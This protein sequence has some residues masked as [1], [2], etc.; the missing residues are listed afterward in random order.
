MKLEALSDTTTSGRLKVAN[1]FL[2]KVMVAAVIVVGCTSS[3]LECVSIINRNIRPIN[4]P[5]SRCVLESKALWAMTTDVVGLQG[6]IS[7][8][9]GRDH[10][11]SH[12]VLHLYPR[13]PHIA[14]NK[15]LHA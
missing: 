5:C 15:A 3:H 10:I 4:G 13:P 8:F 11:I 7:D 1:D 6:E 12:I 9:A 2:S 14:S